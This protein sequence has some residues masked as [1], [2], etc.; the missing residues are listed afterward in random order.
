MQFLLAGA[1]PRAGNC[2]PLRGTSGSVTVHLRQAIVPSAVSLVHVPPAVAF[3]LRS[4][5]NKFRVVAN[6]PGSIA[7]AHILG[8]FAFAE[9]HDG[10]QRFELNSSYALDEIIFQVSPP[11]IYETTAIHA[12]AT[13]SQ[14]IE[15]FV[16]RMPQVMQKMEAYAQFS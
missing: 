4:A 1:E 5:P 15:L 8:S 13:A 14:N 6:K 10:R 2:L 16:L 3:D 7:P 9:K 12:Y 11:S